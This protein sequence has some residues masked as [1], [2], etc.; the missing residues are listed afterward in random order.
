MS[1]LSLCCSIRIELISS[2]TSENGIHPSHDHAINQYGGFGP[3]VLIERIELTA[4]SFN[5]IG[6]NQCGDTFCGIGRAVPK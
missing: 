5:N 3:S 1:F 4:I 2:H 6:I